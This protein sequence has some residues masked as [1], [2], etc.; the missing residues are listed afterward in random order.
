[1]SASKSLRTVIVPTDFSRGA[2]RALERVALLPLARHAVV[3]V[4]HVIDGPNKRTSPDAIRQSCERAQS[5]L[6]ARSRVAGKSAPECVVKILTGT[7]HVEIIRFARTVDADLVVLG[8]K[9]AGQRFRQVLGRTAA[10]V[11]LKGELPLLIVERAPNRPYQRPLLAVEFDPC[12]RGVV[13]LARAV[14]GPGVSPLPAVHA[15][16]V[17]F[18]GFIPPGTDAQ[19]SL[20]HQH[21]RDAAERRLKAFLVSEGMKG[22]RLDVRLRRGEPAWVVLREARRSRSDLIALGTHGRVG[23]AHAILGSVAEE[24]VIGA[25]RDV[26]IGRPVRH[27]FEDLPGE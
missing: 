27:T 14:V 11:A 20:H 24:V 3:Y 4:V 6:A 21:C 22:I 23:I 25:S 5:Q 15:F 2:Q 26:L 16:H 10:Q 7:P 9:G 12:V 1:M 8:R 13:N 18:E 19:P 17:P